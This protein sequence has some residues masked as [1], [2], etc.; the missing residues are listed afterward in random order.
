MITPD[1]CFA[2]Q[3]AEASLNQIGGRAETAS[4]FSRRTTQGP[5][6]TSF[7]PLPKLPLQDCADAATAT[8]QSVSA[9]STETH[10]P[11]LEFLFSVSVLRRFSSFG[12]ETTPFGGGGEPRQA[13]SPT[14]TPR[15]F[16]RAV[17]VSSIPSPTSDEKDPPP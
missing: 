3:C 9:G 1:N 5:V 13:G 16:A 12:G 15:G 6:V 14:P 11:K 7:G 4:P 17:A 10:L 2:R 8:L